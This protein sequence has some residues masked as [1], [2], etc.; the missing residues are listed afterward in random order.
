LPRATLLDELLP[1]V[2]EPAKQLGAIIST[3]NSIAE[4]VI[5]DRGKRIRESKRILEGRR[6]EKASWRWA[7]TLAVT[8]LLE[9]PGWSYELKFEGYRAL[10]VKAN[11]KVRLLSRNGKDVT[12]RFASIARALEALPPTS[13]LILRYADLQARYTL[14]KNRSNISSSDLN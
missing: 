2:L 9:E 1:P 10:G 7:W 3:A 13:R 12:R 14:G 4:D 11:G 5:C 6:K 8:K